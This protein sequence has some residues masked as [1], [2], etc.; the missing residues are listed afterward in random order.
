MSTT[1]PGHAAKLKQALVFQKEL[2]FFWKE[3][4]EAGEVDLLLV[5][6]DLREVRVVGEVRGQVLCHSVLDIEPEVAVALVR[7]RRVGV[8]VGGHRADAIWLDL[9]RPVATGHL[10]TGQRAGCRQS[11][12]PPRRHRTPR[13]T[14]DPWSKRTGR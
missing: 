11:E 9:E 8:D 14:P 5:G 6:L 7:D 4:A 2:A 12:H 13:S 3:E 1:S 10:D